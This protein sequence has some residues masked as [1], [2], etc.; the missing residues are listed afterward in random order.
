[1]KKH[2][3]NNKKSNSLL[4]Y[5]LLMLTLTSCGKDDD[6]DGTDPADAAPGVEVCVVFAPNELGDCGYADRVLA[7]IHLFDQQLSQGDYN[8]VS[9]GEVQRLMA[10]DASGRVRR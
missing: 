5:W 4:M 7:G 2:V 1:M 3:E 8:R 9:V 6:D 10:G